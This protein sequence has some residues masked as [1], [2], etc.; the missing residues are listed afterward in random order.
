VVGMSFNVEMAHAFVDWSKPMIRAE[1]TVTRSKRRLTMGVLNPLY[2]L[3]ELIEKHPN[4]IRLPPKV[5]PKSNYRY[6]KMLKNQW[7]SLL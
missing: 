4:F 6:W 3:L 1:I 2:K 7:D 5:V